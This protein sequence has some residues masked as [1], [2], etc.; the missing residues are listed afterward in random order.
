MYARGSE[1]R[2]WDLHV[3]SPLSALEN[4]FKD[5][6]SYLEALESSDSGVVG[7]GITDYCSIEGYKKILN[8]RNQ[9]RLQNFHVI[10]PNIEFRIQPQLP[11]GSGIN[12]HILVSPEDSS[13]IRLVE[14]ALSQLTFTYK[15]NRY[16]CT[17]EGLE[18]LG[19]A[20]KTRI[21][22]ATAAFRHGVSQFKPGF[23]D[24]R[25]WYHGHK[26]LRLNSLVV[27]ANNSKDG[28]SGLG[29][30]SGFAAAR[31]E[32]YRFAHAIFSGNPRDRDYFLGKGTDSPEEIIR[33]LGSLKPCIHGSDA[34]SER[35]LF[36]PDKERA[37]WIK[38]DPCFEGLR[39][40]THEPQERVHIGPTPPQPV[41]RSK[42]I[43]FVSFKNAGR[44]FSQT[45]LP[46]NNG[47][48]A[49]IGE[50]GSGKTAL[51]DLIAYGC[52]A[53]VPTRSGS[54]FIQKAGT[55]LTGTEVKLS[56]ADGHSCSGAVGEELPDGHSEDLSAARYLS[57]DFVEELC[58]DDVSGKRLVR[59]IEQVI[60]KHISEPDRLCCSSFDDLRRAKTERITQRKARIRSRLSQINSQIVELEDTTEARAA[61]RRTI[62]KIN[63]DIAA[64]DRQLPS[65][66]ALFATSR[67]AEWL[68]EKKELLQNLNRELGSVKWL[69]NRIQTARAK[70]DDF[71]RTIDE[72]F[73][74]FEDI[75]R[76]I[77]LPVPE[78][79]ISQFKPTF[80]PSLAQ[81]LEHYE[82][83][84]HKEAGRIQGD[85]SSSDPNTIARTLRIISLAEKRTAVD[86]QLQHRFKNLQDRRRF[87]E[88]ERLRLQNEVSNIEDKVAKELS[89]KREERWQIYLSYFEV[90]WE[91]D[92]TLT[93]LYEPLKEALA[94]DTTGTTAGFEFSVRQ[95]V[96]VQSWMEGGADLM[97]KRRRE[98]PLGKTDTLRLIQRELLPPWQMGIK[99][100]IRRGL[101]K[102]MADWASEPSRLNEN[103]VSHASRGKFYD[104]L[105]STEHVRL[106]YSLR[107][108]GTDLE[109][110]SPGARGIVL[111]ILYLA[112]DEGDTRPLIIDQPEGN[113]DN[114][115]IYDSLVPFLRLAKRYRQILLITHN[116]NLVVATDA[117]QIVIATAQRKEGDDH[118]QI[119]YSSGS[120]ESS[121]GIL[122]IRKNVV[123]LLEGGK[124]A[125]QVRDKKY[126]MDFLE[127]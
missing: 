96:D 103:L 62:Q 44:W 77:R 23:D 39:Q 117:E 29:K 76:D 25:E 34:H 88:E 35:K 12:I 87:L 55:Y 14:Q 41:D 50:K 113:L 120:L 33:K 13:H 95:F 20:H 99:D 121:A 72:Q 107:Y 109:H 82:T 3:H 80:P 43:K 48:I 70:Q 66:K 111:L 46:L 90:L 26:W 83:H 122:S 56:W 69:L 104:W 112:M 24:F 7:L 68:E 110:L 116:P 49:V 67:T 31:E 16:P 91:E 1:W 21:G 45:M 32:L 71:Q 60:F 30:D 78:D 22:D 54:S 102:F 115:S 108:R 59:E 4:G 124:E 40:V 8:Y 86:V 114:S 74:E 57:Q 27:V 100:A 98:V 5:W 58:S 85:E 51:A 47:L 38:A 118:P 6:D 36:M 101:E 126:A 105:F 11:G 61:K 28:A 97:D 42:I 37:C 89:Q 64:I 19:R 17:R 73:G 10:L 2:R 81:L 18:N 52:G 106:E 15:E 125:F 75:L 84:L 63:D 127:V 123:R 79:T 119:S 53:W 92:R 94:R 93:A 9:K 65:L